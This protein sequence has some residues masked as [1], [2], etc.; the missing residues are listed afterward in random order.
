MDAVNLSETKGPRIL[1]VFWAFFAVSVIMV[2]A[3]L[4]IRA[5]WLR[6]IGLDDYII[7]ASMI[8]VSSYTIITTVN[9][10]FGFGKHTPAITQEGGTDLLTKVLLVNYIDFAFGILSFTMPKLAI[11]ALLNRVL[12]PGRFHRTWL[13]V[14][15][16]LVFIS[17][18][19]CIIVLFTMC[20][21]PEAMWKP[22]L[23]AAGAATCRS[24]RI[25]VGYAIFTG[26][27]SGFADLYLAI[28]PTVVLARL[29]ITLKKKLALCAALGL[30]AG[31]RDGDCQ[32]LSAAKSI[33]YG[34][35][36]ME[37]PDATADLVIWTSIESNIIVIASCIPTLGPLFEL[38]LGR[39]SWSSQERYYYKDK[40]SNNQPPSFSAERHKRPNLGTYK[41]ADLFITNNISTTREGS[42][43]SILRPDEQTKG[44]RPAGGIQRTD[45]VV[46]EYEMRPLEVRRAV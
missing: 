18:S 40:G 35:L 9:V 8:M 20:D 37:T 2:S 15:T 41:D 6:N 25:L 3:R 24:N 22:Q 19:I 13:W 17:S 1:G 7:A 43:E 11:S 42:Q 45:Q 5:R 28:Y 30:G 21:P 36:D 33:Q 31:V 16:A 23:V 27:I 14:L 10:V 34:G 29:Q 32:V 4:Y 39:R 12:N 38:I 44:R 26:A 46:V